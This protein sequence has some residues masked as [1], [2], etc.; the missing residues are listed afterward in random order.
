[1][2]SAEQ[3]R[4]AEAAFA[5]RANCVI[6]ATSALELGI[7][8]G[9]LDRVIQI[10]AP[11]TVSR[12]LQRMGRTGRRNGAGRNCLFLSTSDEALVQATALIKLWRAGYIEPINAPPLPYHVV[13]Q[14][15]MALSLQEQGIER[16]GCHDWIG[17]VPFV[18]ALASTELDEIIRW[19][20][21]QGILWDDDGVLCFA[22]EGEARFSR[23][24][25]MELLSIFTS[26][27]LFR[28]FHG[29]QELGMVDQLSLIGR[30]RDARVILLGGRAWVV[31]NI[32]WQRRTAYVT[33]TDSP[34]R[35]RW[36]GEAQGL[37][38]AL[39]QE[40][41][42]VLT[43]TATQEGLSQRAA[44]KIDEIRNG[45][46]MVADA[47]HTMLT[48]GPT[49]WEWWTFGG[50][51]ANASIA[52]A[53]RSHL[54]TRVD[55]GSLLI[56]IDGDASMETVVHALEDLRSREASCFQPEI[57]DRAL[58]GLKF[59]ECIPRDLGIASL[60]ARLVDSVAVERILAEPIR[61]MSG[62]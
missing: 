46:D 47:D 53:V 11:T 33:P 29:R 35:S 52:P 48:R 44:N 10:D 13:A 40:M 61:A 45:H 5:S 15:I 51:K 55:F 3:R 37:S 18:A 41:R 20:L 34:G 49:R 4:D 59:S 23:R 62:G 17:R 7:D 42:Q 54:D 39:C 36:F 60:Q 2:L 25:Y 38:Y 50:A 31:T 32:D 8:I 16:T 26:P 56:S 27:P 30:R 19:M 6:V 14:Q 1:M 12:F 9:D 57:D 21:S 22:E 58:E 24:N 28:V 43:S